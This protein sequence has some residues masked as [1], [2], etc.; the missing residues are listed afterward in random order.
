MS[1]KSDVKAKATPGKR[2][3]G[4]RTRHAWGKRVA[5]TS[6]YPYKRKVAP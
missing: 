1:G 2:R 3:G 5:R 6:P 4:S